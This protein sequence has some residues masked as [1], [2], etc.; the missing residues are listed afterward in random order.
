MRNRPVYVTNYIR[1]NSQPFLTD[2][3][4]SQQLLNMIDCGAGLIDVRG[5]MFCRTNGEFTKNPSAV[6]QQKELISEIH[7]CG[8]KA[9][10]STHIFEYR[11]PKNILEIAL[12]QE[13]RGA[14]IA[15]IVTEANSEKEADDA[16]KTL[17]LLKE[18]L[19]IPF[20]FLCNGS[21]CKNHRLLSSLLGNCMCL[22][23]ENENKN[24]NQP[25]LQEA[26]N[27]LKIVK[28]EKIKHEQQ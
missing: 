27:I 24:Q 25:T 4:L 15:K 21:H 5:D 28:K 8:A 16:F 19:K 9:L 11:T 26:E 2:K 23:V 1:D 17:F 18:N 13:E 6:K 22:C 3:E 14:D 7:R 20:L 12:A 10:I